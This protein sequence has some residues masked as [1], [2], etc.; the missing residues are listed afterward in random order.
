V[1]LP[2]H[3]E[4][5]IAVEKL[6][7]FLLDLEHEKGKSRGTVLY[8]IGFTRERWEELELRFDSR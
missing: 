6:R 7:D 8:G 1:L 3:A 4:A 5:T 2:N